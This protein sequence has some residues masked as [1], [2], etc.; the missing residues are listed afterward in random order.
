M[1]HR[2]NC[3]R[4]EPEFAANP[5]DD[6]QQM[7]Q[8]QYEDDEI[9]AEAEESKERRPKATIFE[10]SN[11]DIMNLLTGNNDHLNFLDVKDPCNFLLANSVPINGDPNKFPDTDDDPTSRPR[12]T[13]R[14]IQPWVRTCEFGLRS[15]TSWNVSFRRT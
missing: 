6:R 9:I 1:K 7:Q 11:D 13:T 3:V 8:Q 14:K 10:I 5:L 4:N 2:E 12:R 15:R